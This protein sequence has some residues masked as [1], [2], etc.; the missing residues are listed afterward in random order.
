MLQRLTLSP[1]A[2]AGL[3]GQETRIGPYRIIRPL[4]QGGMGVVSLAEQTQPV[5]R[6]VAIKLL[7]A[8]VDSD[9][10]VAR[11]ETERQAL[12]GVEH[13]DNTNVLGAGAGECGRAHLGVG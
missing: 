2:S 1:T 13:P 8:G 6:E 9:V 11:F 3:A 7:T 12:A 5:R 4:G 10:I